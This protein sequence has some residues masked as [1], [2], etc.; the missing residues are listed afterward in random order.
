VAFT[1][2]SLKKA[3]KSGV[4]VKFAGP[5]AG[6]LSLKGLKGSKTVAAG[7][8]QI[9]ASG[10]GTVTLKFTKAG[11]KALKKARSVKLTV[12]LAYTPAGGQ[13]VSGS[14]KITLKK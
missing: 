12:R 3:L 5:G 9:A 1:K 2:T 8:G 10:K 13:T 11:V 7:S 6:T 14:T 4:K